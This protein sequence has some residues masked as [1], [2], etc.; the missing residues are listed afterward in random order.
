MWK[1]HGGRSGK[2]KEERE[3]EG[4]EMEGKRRRTVQSGVDA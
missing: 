1:D 2:V 4:E 3:S